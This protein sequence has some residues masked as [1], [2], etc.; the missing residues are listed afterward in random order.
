[1]LENWLMPQLN[2]DGCPAH[3]HKDVRGYLIR[4]LPQSWIGR[5]GNENH[6]FMRWPLRSPDLS[7]CEFFFWGFVEDTVFVSPLPAN[8]QD[9]R[10]RITANVA[11][12]DRDMLTRVGNEMDYR[13]NVCRITKYGYIEHLEIYKKTLRVSLS[14]GVRITMI[15]CVIYLLR[16]FKMFHGLMNNILRDRVLSLTILR[17]F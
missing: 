5:K 6:A 10:N 4:N 3:Y 2:E 12:V 13:I 8:L 16:I 11:L 14:I 17:V 9:L 1:M 7:P 15:H